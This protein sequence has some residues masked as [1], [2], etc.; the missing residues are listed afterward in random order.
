MLSLFSAYAYVHADAD[1][2]RSRFFVVGSFVFFFDY[3][4]VRVL[5]FE[6]SRDL[7]LVLIKQLLGMMRWAW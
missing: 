3:D 5:V 1:E 7:M 2:V 6:S 4:D